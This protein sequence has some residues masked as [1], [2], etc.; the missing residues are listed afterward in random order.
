MKLTGDLR[1]LFKTKLF[2]TL[3]T[4]LFRTLFKMH[5]KLMQ[6][7]LFIIYLIDYKSHLLGLLFRVK[8]YSTR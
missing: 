7:T 1:T 8:C 2:R 5:F 3:K 4:N 6:S